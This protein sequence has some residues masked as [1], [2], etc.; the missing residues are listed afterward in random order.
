[1]WIVRQ[2]QNSATLKKPKTFYMNFEKYYSV[3][4]FHYQ[5]KV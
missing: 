3:K 4:M 2:K 5:K 1:M